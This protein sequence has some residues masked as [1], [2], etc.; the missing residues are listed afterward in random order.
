MCMNIDRCVE[1]L[2]KIQFYKNTP[3]W[4]EIY[5]LHLNYCIFFFIKVLSCILHAV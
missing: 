4:Y 5:H 2:Q 1:M 3:T